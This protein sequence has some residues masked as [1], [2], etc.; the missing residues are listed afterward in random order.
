MAKVRVDYACTSCGFTTPK[1]LGRCPDCGKWGS[2]VEE[3][4]AAEPKYRVV[5]DGF[6]ASK[7]VRLTDVSDT[8]ETRAK[9][10]I[11]EFDRVMGG[12]VVPSSATLI[13]GDPG[14]GKSTILL[15]VAKGLAR[16]GKPVL[17]VS[18]E[19]SEAQVK[20]RAARLGVE[21]REIFLLSETSVEK[22]M[23]V[24]SEL[25][26]STLLIDSIQTMFTSDLPGAPGSVG[27]VRECAGRLVFYGKKAGMSVFLVGHVTKEGTIAGPRVLEH[28]V[29]TVLYFEGEKGHPYRILKAVKNRF[30]STN[31]IGVFEMRASGLSEVADPS[32]LFLSE[33]SGDTSGALVF[34][35]IEGTRPLLVEVQALASQS[36]LAMPR[37]TTL[38][39]DTNRVILL[40]A[41]LEKKAGFS[42]YNQDIFVNVAGGFELDETAADL[43]LLCAVAASFKDQVIPAGTAAF[44]EVGL[45]GEVRAVPMAEQRLNEAARMGFT[46]VILPASNAERLSA[47]YPLTLVP[48]RH[49]K[50]ALAQAWKK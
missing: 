44:G 47:K 17:Y 22:V 46:R 10:G 13:G 9:S 45:G 27:Q 38:G 4:A 32:G 50:E 36:F 2:L 8:A 35:A 48:V 19:E 23:T 18:G 28:L 12:G 16:E 42:L 43:A 1:W 5:V 25:S 41:I 37:R 7:P 3:V 6:P 39:A 31:E 29:D 24:A 26:P 30:G 40:C 33:R 14:I 21:E 49:I 34:P 20:L 11:A 15:Q